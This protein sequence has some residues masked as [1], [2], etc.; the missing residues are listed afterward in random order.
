[1]RESTKQRGLALAAGSTLYGKPMEDMTREELL[2]TA[3][4][5]W[6]AY[7]E[8]LQIRLDQHNRKA[9]PPCDMREEAGYE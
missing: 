9:I 6:N 1:M 5:G 2:A 8:Q 4:L 3:A 7:K